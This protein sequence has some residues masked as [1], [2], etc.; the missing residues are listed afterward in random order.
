MMIPDEKKRCTIIFALCIGVSLLLF[1]LLPNVGQAVSVSGES[2]TILRMERAADD[3][4]LLP[5]YEYL[6]L[7]IENDLKEGALSGDFGG[8]GRLDTRDR[9][10]GGRAEGAFQ[11]GNVSYQ[12]NNNN[13]QFTAGRQFV[14]E[15]V[16]A[17]RLDGLYLHSD[18]AGGFG[19]AAYVGAPVVTEPNFKGG[20]VTYGGRF[21]HSV[22][23]YYSLGLSIL[24][25]NYDGNRIREEAG[26]DLWLHP[27]PK[28]DLA[29]RSSYN[30]VTSG[31][32]EH[33]Y[34]LTFNPLGN[35]RISADLAG[36]NY[37]DYFQQMTTS[38]FSLTTGIIDPDERQFSLGGGIEVSPIEGLALVVDYRNYD[39]KI[40][41]EAKYF[42]GKATFTA[43]ESFM[44]GFSLHRMAG[45]TA[46]LTYDEYRLFASKTLGKASLMADFFDVK[47]DSAISGIK[48]TYCASVGVGYG[49]SEQLQLAVAVDYSK[50]IDFDHNL[51]GLI[52]LT[53]S[54][55]K[56]FGAGGG[57]K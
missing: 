13:L 35:L 11:Y 36:I 37:R 5:I 30:S 48:N 29:G 12:G 46:R 51:M 25:T 6:S 43:S 56:T 41:G 16:A 9:R 32:M 39:Y 14:A 19:A 42:G 2:Q 33:A 38:V 40:A 50:S 15:G 31:W 1:L 45:E 18:F 27:L 17:E 54:F 20:D 34:A 23:K 3:R 24:Q 53:Y 57:G 44:V 47:Y 52:K 22:P 4:K 49:I 8:W 7:G 10:P 55:D 28:L 26:L 21:S